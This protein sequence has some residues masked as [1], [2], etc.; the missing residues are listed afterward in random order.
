MACPVLESQAAYR[1]AR[2]RIAG[3]PVM[4]LSAAQGVHRQTV[5]A[6]RGSPKLSGTPE[7]DTP[8][9]DQFRA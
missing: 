5:R 1:V 3:L 6:E 4:A 2:L 8:S 9:A 7:M